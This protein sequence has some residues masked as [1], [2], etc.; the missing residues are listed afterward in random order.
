[1]LGRTLKLILDLANRRPSPRQPAALD[2]LFAALRAPVP[3]R[4]VAELEDDI[5]DLW[6]HH[7]D[8]LC[9]GWMSQA[10]TA[11]AMH[12]TDDALAILSRIVAAAPDWAEAWNKRATLHYMMGRD[13]EALA[14]ID[15]TVALEPRHFGAIAGFGHI[16]LRHGDLTAAQAAF[17]EA[18]RI[19]PHLQDIRLLA[20]EIGREL[21]HTLN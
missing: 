3:A 16:A 7:P 15:R 13:V 2:D 17:E 20:I 8:A 12:H 21:P 19:H 1:M 4:P 6:S 14:D 5:W 9:D 10:V 18:L 11:M